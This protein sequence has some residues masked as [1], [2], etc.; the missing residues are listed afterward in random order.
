MNPGAFGVF[1][2]WFVFFITHFCISFAQ[3]FDM[4]TLF[5]LFASF[6]FIFT[7]FLQPL[8]L[9]PFFSSNLEFCFFLNHL[10]HLTSPSPLFAILLSL[11]FVSCHPISFSRLLI[12]FLSIPQS[13]SISHPHCSPYRFPSFTSFSAMPLFLSSSPL[14][15]HPLISLLLASSFFLLPRL[16][17]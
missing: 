6:F 2:Y 17:L 13:P 9:F 7:D 15:R 14:L 11:L 16:G 12:S 10:Q 3:F 5:H 1:V 8:I 4:A